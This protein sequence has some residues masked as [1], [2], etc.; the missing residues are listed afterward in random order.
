MTLFAADLV[1]FFGRFHSLVVHL[2][3]GFILLAAIFEWISWKKKVDLNIAISFGLLL[4]SIF[5]I[6]AIIF[7]FFLLSGG[8]YSESGS[9]IHK[10]SGIATA[11]FSLS[12]WGLR[13]YDH[14]GN[15]WRKAYFMVF[16]STIALVLTTGHFGGNLTHGSNYLFEHAPNPIR[17]L[18]GLKP[19][20]IRITSMDSA[21]VYLDVVHPILE[22]KCN[23]C[24]NEDKSKGELIM[25]DWESIIK[26]GENGVILVEGDPENSELIRRINLNPNHDDFMPSEGREPLTKA[27]MEL[28]EWWI[29]EHAPS[30]KK[31]TELTL[32]DRIIGQL[33][34]VGIG[35][36]KSFIESLEL[37]A[38]DPQIYQAI[39]SAG[40]KLNTVSAES[41]LLEAT[42]TG[43]KQIELSQD[44]FKILSQANQHITWL[45]L[46]GYHFKDEELQYIGKLNNLT[47][48]KMDRTLVT[49]TGVKQLMPLKNLEYLNLYSTPI[50]D[51]AIEYLKEFKSL[52]KLYVWQTEMSNSGLEKLIEA[53]PGM[54]VIG[55]QSG[56]SLN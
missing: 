21:F 42:Y 37:P 34:Q 50:T 49:D 33:K 16:G 31:I 1:L 44:K 25:T 4:G 35:L 43:D 12:A 41:T 45:N 46:S 13:K 53:L 8:G 22:S 18:A 56:E 20:R 39:V 40:F 28:L 36:E 52:K 47:R 24:H 10:W 55:G 2:P 5:A 27:E 51:E 48:L 6:V 30:D 9:N 3:I 26:G 23:V 54:E 38:L 14:K 15:R 11:L 17:A 19:E 29:R 32:D 7:G